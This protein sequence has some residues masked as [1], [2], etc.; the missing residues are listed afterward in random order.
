MPED[1]HVGIVQ[2]RAINQRAHFDEK[3]LATGTEHFLRRKYIGTYKK[4]GCDILSLPIWTRCGTMLKPSSVVFLRP[5]RDDPG[6]ADA[7]RIETALGIPVLRHDEKKPGGIAEVLAFFEGR[8][9][10][11]GSVSKLH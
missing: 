10:D 9:P 4:I 2:D 7:I 11:G 6:Y 8:D 5:C 3:E 1:L